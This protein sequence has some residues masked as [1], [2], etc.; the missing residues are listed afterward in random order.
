M[1]LYTYN[2]NG[3]RTSKNYAKRQYAHQRRSNCKFPENKYT[4]YPVAT[5]LSLRN[6]RAFKQE[7]EQM[8]YL[9]EA[10]F[11]QE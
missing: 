4:M 10:G 8:R 6:A 7:F 1:L 2:S 5:G 9:I 3:I 11:D